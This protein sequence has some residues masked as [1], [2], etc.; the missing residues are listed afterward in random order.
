LATPL[1]IEGEDNFPA[2]GPWIA[3]ANHQ[4][5]LDGFAITA[6]LPPRGAFLVK[7]EIRR[8]T[9]PYFILQRLG[10]LFVERFEAAQ[11]VADARK[12][13]A[14]LRSGQSLI[15]FPEGTFQRAAGLMPFRMGAFVIAAETRTPV[16]PVTL[17]GTRGMLRANQWFPRRGKIRLT[18]SPPLEPKGSDWSAA[19]ELRDATRAA[20]LAHAEEPD[21]ER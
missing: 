14:A 2:D 6:A 16:V 1:E 15:V 19:I 17:Q 4:S 11:S 10:H 7:S 18:I 3:V 12:A 9:L 13:V 21:L 5:Y 8:K 20:I